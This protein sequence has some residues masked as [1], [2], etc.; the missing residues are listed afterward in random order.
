[1]PSW[2]N[3]SYGI[4]HDQQ[5]TTIGNY[6]V[7]KFGT[8]YSNYAGMFGMCDGSVRSIRNTIT[9]LPFIAYLTYDGGETNLQE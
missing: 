7:Y 9:G 4:I 6:T 1:M 3:G 5:S 8:P 2:Q